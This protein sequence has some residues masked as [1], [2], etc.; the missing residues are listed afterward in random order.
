MNNSVFSKE[1]S[2]CVSILIYRYICA[3]TRTLAEAGGLF[4]GRILP[5]FFR[6][7]LL[8]AGSAGMLG[9]P[10]QPVG[11]TQFSLFLL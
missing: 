7:H 6:H 8:V 1:K 11:L 4:R 3:C 9:C 5:P 10:I 2:L